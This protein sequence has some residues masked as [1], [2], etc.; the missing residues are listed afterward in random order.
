M[1]RLNFKMLMKNFA[2]YDNSNTTNVKVKYAA[3]S[4]LPTLFQ[5]SNTTNV[6]VKCSHI[7]GGNLKC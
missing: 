6:K 3:Y 1:L 2:V 4:P 5:N 7:R